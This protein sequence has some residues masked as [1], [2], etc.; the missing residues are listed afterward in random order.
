MSY[1]GKSIKQQK[2]VEDEL[3]LKKEE[4][5][6]LECSFQIL[7]KIQQKDKKTSENYEDIREKIIKIGKDI[8]DMEKQV[9][10]TKSTV[11]LYLKHKKNFTEQRESFK[12]KKSIERLS[13]NQ[14]NA[15]IVLDFKQNITLGGG[16]IEIS[17]L[18]Y[19]KK[20]LELF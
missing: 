6:Q 20:R 4:K 7:L 9:M 16:P 11:E 13:N 8:I 15:V 3:N 5:I 1:W 10:E 19:K 14:N 12:F 18:F 2:K 17:N